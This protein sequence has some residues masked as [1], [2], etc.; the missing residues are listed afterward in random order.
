MHLIG[1]KDL[2]TERL[3]LR[4]V[5][6]EDADEAYNNW[7][8]NPKVSFYLPWSVHK[9]VEETKEL[10]AFWEEEY[11][12]NDTFRWIVE[13]K[14]SHELIGTIDVVSFQIDNEVCE[15]GYCYGEPFWKKGYG[16]EA[17]SRV[18]KYLFEEVGVYLIT[19][20]H[21][22]SNIGSGKVMQK[23]GMIFDA[24]LRSRVLDKAG[25]RDSLMVYSITKDEYFKNNR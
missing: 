10:Y 1:T 7:C 8:S 21:Y 22:S 25:N 11:K 9:N 3:L 24:K 5:R 6:K 2:E 14:E 13:L 15:V 23:S 19:A 4:K 20:K 16:T 12:K 18:L 17:L